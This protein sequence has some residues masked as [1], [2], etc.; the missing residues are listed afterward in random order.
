M[1]IETYDSQ[2]PDEAIVVFCEFVQ[3]STFTLQQPPVG[4]QTG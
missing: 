3:E 4:S 2:P 1:I